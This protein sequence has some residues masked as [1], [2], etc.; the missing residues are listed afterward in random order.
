MLETLLDGL[1]RRDR[2]ALSRLL[3][4][5]AR[6]EELHAIDAAFRGLTPP[7]S[8]RS[9]GAA[10]IA[11]T[12][13]A[14]VGK[15]TLVGKLIERARQDGKTIAVLACDPESPITGGALL[16]DRFRMSP[17]DEDAVFIRSLATPSGSEAIAPHLPILVRLLQAFSFDY[18]L[19]ETVGA[20]QADTAV[21]RHADRVVLLIQPETG[22]DLQWEKAGVLEVADVIV[23]HKGDLPGAERTLTQVKASLEMSTQRDIP[24]LLVSSRTGAGIDEL[25]QI[26]KAAPRRRAQGAELAERLRDDFERRLR[27]LVREPAYLSLQES[28]GSGDEIATLREA[29][30]LLLR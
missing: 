16:G 28:F 5:A 9:P 15:S 2:R 19:L 11:I 8:P 3:T 26:V 17:R 18:I 13:S 7:G 6:G 25:W 23:I 12:G 22:D 27:G 14:G 29:W 10:V 1:K 4:L 24:A 21:S 30:R 20:G